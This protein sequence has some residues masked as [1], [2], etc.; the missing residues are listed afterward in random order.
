MCHRRRMVVLAG[1][2]LGTLALSFGHP[3]AAQTLDLRL[4]VD[5]IGTPIVGAIVRLLGS[6]GEAF[7]GLTDEAGRLLIRAPEPGSYR[8]RIDRIGSTGLTTDPFSLEAGRTVYKV[9]SMASSPFRLP[10]VEVS[11]FPR[12][13][14][15]GPRSEAAVALWEEVQKALTAQVITA[16][17]GLPLHIRRFVR[18]VDVRGGTQREWVVTSRVSREAPFESLA[19]GDLATRGF[20]YD[21]GDTAVFAAPDA[22]LLLSSAF[23]STHCFYAS[24]D[25]GGLAGLRFLPLVGRRVPEVTGILWLDRET[26]QLRSLDFS[27]TGLGGFLG[28]WNLGGRIDFTRVPGG[29]WIVSQWHVRMPRLEASSSRGRPRLAGYLDN[30]GHAEITLD[31]TRILHHA[32]LVGRVWD[33]TA[34]RGLAGAAVSLAA[35]TVGLLADSAGAFRITLSASGPV[36]VSVEHPNLGLLGDPATRE[37]VLSL[38]DTTFIEFAVPSIA[39]FARAHC[40]RAGRA[41]YVSIVGTA[42]KADGSPAV[43]QEV[44]ALRRGDGADLPLRGVRP[45]RVGKSGTFG[46]CGAPATG[47]LRVMLRSAGAV[48]ADT[49]VVLRGASQWIELKA[50]S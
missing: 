17:L 7:R 47:T 27:Y 48:P 39:T 41:G 29:R 21:V 35:G 1:M 43:G 10:T 3:L 28:R 44:V 26:A 24:G 50:R 30:G 16:S 22:A 18:E 45:A 42:R 2:G 38:G 37:A 5:S 6:G 14:L 15:P 8:L 31:T 12:C 19:P 49:L 9:I 25:E 13:E 46:I 40:P 11:A 34:G 4:R 32:V 23:V 33:S 36:A 20:A